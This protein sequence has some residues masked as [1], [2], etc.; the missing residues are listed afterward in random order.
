[1]TRCNAEID[2]PG[3]YLGRQCSRTAVT[4]FAGK[5]YCKQHDPAMMQAKQLAKHDAYQRRQI[6]QMRAHIA[7]ERLVILHAAAL[8]A[9]RE[10]A[11]GHINPREL[12]QS[13]LATEGEGT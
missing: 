6:A 10:I 5:A 1:M 2:L 11:A 4:G 12:A 3:G 8:S 13:V 7:S 9:I